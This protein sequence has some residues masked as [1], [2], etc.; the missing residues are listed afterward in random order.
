MPFESLTSTPLIRRLNAQ[1]TPSQMALVQKLSTLNLQ[2]MELLAPQPEFEAFVQ[3]AFDQHCGELEPKPKVRQVY[4]ESR[5]A[6][7]AQIQPLPPTVMDAVVQRIVTGQA[8]AQ[9]SRNAQFRHVSDEGGAMQ[10][11]AGLTAKAFDEFVDDLASGLASRYQAFIQAYWDQSPLG[12]TDTGTR[13]Q[14]LLALRIEQARTEVAL[15][16]NDGL[17]SAA[18]EALFESVTRFPD[19][20][21]RQALKGY[22]PCVF[23][24]ALKGAE[25]ANLPLYGAFVLTARDPQDA[26][27]TWETDTPAAAQVRAV[28]ATS[29]LGIVLVC[30]PDEGVEAFDSLASLDR[31]LHRRLNHP[32]EFTHLLQLMADKDQSLGLALH[33]E[34]KA[35]EQIRYLEWLDSPFSHCME[36]QCRKL[37]ENFIATVARYQSHDLQGDRSGLPQSLDDVTDLERAFNGRMV[38]VA[39]LKKRGK[40]QLETFLESATDA[41]KLAWQAAMRAYS[42]ALAN[43][44]ETEGLPSFAQFSDKSR[45]LAYSKAQLRERLQMDYAIQDDPDAILVHMRAPQ[46]SSVPFVPGAPAAAPHVQDA[47]RYQQR[48]SSLTEL[49]LENV[50]GLDFNFTHFSRLTDKSG[51]P[52]T[53]LT[54]EQVKELV[55]SANIGNRY[56]VFLKDRLITSPEALAQKGQFARCLALQVRLDAIEAKIAG[57]FLPDRLE[58]GFNWVRVVLDQPVDSDQ[59]ETVEGHRILVQCLKLRGERVRGVWLFRTASSSVGSTVVYA[60]QAPAGRVFHEFPDAQLF[61]GFTFNS[62]WRNYLVSRVER[63]QQRRIRSILQGRGDFTLVHMPR[64][65]NHFLEEAYEVEANFAINDAAALSTTTAQT[66]IDTGIAVATAAFDIASMV[67]PIKVM[68]PIGLARSLFSIFNAVDAASLSDRSETAHYLVRALGEFTGALVDGAMGGLAGARV[69]TTASRGVNPLMALRNKPGEVQV[70]AGWE[71]KGLYYNTSGEAGARQYFLNEQNRWFSLL[72]EGGEKAWRV[73]DARKPHRYH[74]EPIRLDATGHWEVGSHP[75]T[76]LRGGVSPTQQLMELYPFLTEHQARL[77]FD[78][79]NFPRGRE[80]EFQLDVVQTL[81]AGAS[82][83]A[84]NL[85]LRVT[86]QRLSMRLRGGELPGAA[87]TAI[88]PQPGPSRAASNRP[89]VERFIDWGQAIDPVERQLLDGG[90]GIYRRTGGAA[91]WVGTDYIEIDQRYYAVLPSGAQAH[92]EYVFMRDP[93]QSLH[94]Y[95]Q[96]ESLLRADPYDQ[97]R[98]ARFAPDDGRWINT[99]ELTF[100]KTL[101]GSVGDAFPMLTASSQVDVARALFNVHNPNGLTNKGMVGMWEALLDWRGVQGS[102]QARSADPHLMLPTTPRMV[103]GNWRLDRRAGQYTHLSLRTERIWV[104]L[105]RVVTNR[106]HGALKL[107]MTEVLRRNGYR[108]ITGYNVSAEL[109]FRRPGREAVYWLRLRRVVGDIIDGQGSPASPV[110]L[111]MTAFAREKVTA[112]RASNSLVP[113]VGGVHMPVEGGAASIFIIRV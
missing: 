43:L 7:S 57:D 69:A 62:S 39:R 88:E 109:L 89:P 91:R 25:A 47:P 93:H 94:T 19:A 59:R 5:D 108:I 4:L 85:H 100:Q 102:T 26:E 15:L 61:S 31:E 41:D 27:V 34:A 66:D 97:P 92:S 28:Q 21:A 37:Q 107:L 84:F 96:F 77:V 14:R 51:A 58:R 63:A 12:A 1:D 3:H 49:A 71:G 81:R 35:D 23:G 2:V 104:A 48:K 74:H 42:D 80:L 65:A 29:N 46:V 17:V 101:S 38:P 70:L 82:L 45:L 76:G 9:A 16:K 67:L 103:D 6:A 105:Q 40:A 73:K 110:D 54:V 20:L 64:I 55:R 60:P 83:D 95:D 75:G 113:L 30:W 106:A 10:P 56:D 78:S 18:G 50:G 53:A 36:D 11:I 68:V 33:R 99:S 79:F 112:A 98:L 87:P 72:D 22:K 24:L 52:Y 13:R 8:S 32:V 44:P 111:L 86:P 90:L